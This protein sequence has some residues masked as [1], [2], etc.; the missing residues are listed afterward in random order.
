M[1]TPRFDQ[2]YFELFS[3]DPDLRIDLR[4]LDLS[5]HSILKECHPDRFVSSAEGEKRLSVQY[6]S[7]V[8][9]AYSCLRNDLS[10]AQY[11]LNLVGISAEQ[12]NRQ[13][14]STN[15]LMTQ[16]TLRESL[17]DIDDGSD[18]MHDLDELL[19]HIDEERSKTKQELVLLFAA[20]D[21]TQAAPLVVQWQ[22]LDKLAEEAVARQFD[23]EAD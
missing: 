5:Y 3:L 11:L 21:Y 22:F 8:N 2:N 16:M 14:A 19:N 1:F 10:R 20:K 12:L 18:A 7:F 9:E 4:E 13:Q 6:S 15:F 17:E 23:L